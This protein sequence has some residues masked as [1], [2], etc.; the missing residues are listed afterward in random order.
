MSYILERYAIATAYLDNQ[1]DEN[2]AKLVEYVKANDKPP[3]T[4]AKAKV[5]RVVIPTIDGHAP[6]AQPV[7][8]AFLDSLRYAGLV[9]VHRDNEQGQC[10]DLLPPAHIAKQGAKA[11][12][13]WADMNACRMKSLGYN[14]VEA[15]ATE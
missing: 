4:T 2:W 14:A 7:N 10:F 12:G 8:G 6:L 5:V 11:T 9:R 13:V 15:P 1:T 3:K